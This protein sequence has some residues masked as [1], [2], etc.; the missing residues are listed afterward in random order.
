ML[1]LP[2]GANPSMSGPDA[3][4]LPFRVFH[5]GSELRVDEL[6]MQVAARRG[7]PVQGF[8]EELR[9]H[10]GEVKSLMTYAAP[11]RDAAGGVYG[12]VGTFADVT[13]SKEAERRY[14][15][16]LE[17]LKLHIDNTPVAALEWDA[18]ACI[19]RWSPAAE[20]MF[21]WT[22]QEAL[23][24][25]VEGLGLVHEEDR[26]RVAELMRALVT[27]GA[28]RNKSLNR[29][30]RKSGDVVWCEW[31]NS[32]LR[33][34]RGTLVSVL[35]LAMDATERQALEASL[36]RQAERLAEADWRKNEF[37][38]MLGHELRNPLA[39]VR[40]ALSVMAIKGGDGILHRNGQQETGPARGRQ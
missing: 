15:E 30:R 23:G 17:R 36:R 28:E 37:L 7:E 5:E 10:D 9:F 34:E 18:D 4:T 3:P 2:D 19:L 27:D 26:G 22:E 12:C 31:Y 20:R 13:A 25:S 40:N 16:T 6:P 14:R 33:D 24:Q 38:A 32:A 21:G 8:E 29:N 1:R 39:P 11:L 35:S